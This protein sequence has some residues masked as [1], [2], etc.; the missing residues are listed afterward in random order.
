L[1]GKFFHTFTEDVPRKGRG[2]V[3]NQGIVLS[4]LGNGYFII[5]LFDFAMGEPSSRHVVSFQRMVANGWSFYGSDG[6]MRDR[7]E[8]YYARGLHEAGD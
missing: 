2:E 1:V 5:Q 7:W 4:D 8:R 3:Q 6:E